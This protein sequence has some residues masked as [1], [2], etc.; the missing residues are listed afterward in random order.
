MKTKLIYLILI[1]AA[2]SFD[3]CKKDEDPKL[4]PTVTTNAVTG[5][6]VSSATLSGTITSNG[7]ATITSSGFVYSSNVAQPTTADNK[8]EITVA[9][10]NFSALLDG[11]TSGTTYHVRAYATNSVGTGYGTVVDFST[12]NLAPVA[13]AVT[14][15]GTVGTGK[16]LT[17]SYTYSDAESD[18][19]SGTT[20]KWYI[21]TDAQGAGET[22]IS[23]ATSSTYVIQAGDLGKFIR[24]GVTPKAGTGTTTGNEVKSTFAGPVLEGNLA[25][26]ASNVTVTGQAQVASQLTATYTYSDPESDVESGSTFQ[27]YVAND[28]AGAGETAISSATTQTYTIQ[29]GDLGKFI[30]FGVTPKAAT[31]KSPG[32]EVK[33]A[34]TVAVGTETVTFTYNGQ[35]VSYGV[36]VSAATGKKWLDRSLGA[37]RAAQAV[38]DYQAYGHYF[39]WGRLADTHQVVT[40]T[41]PADADVTAVNGRGTKTKSTTATP[42]DGLFVREGSAVGGTGDW[43]DPQDDNLWQGVSGVNNPCPS[44][45]R[46][47][48]KDEWTAEGITSLADGFNKLKLTYTGLR[49][50]TD[51]FFYS[52][53]VSGI[54]WTSTPTSDSGFKYSA[55]VRIQNDFQIDLLF[56]R[57]TGLNCRCI[58]D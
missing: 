32:T 17:G 7:N 5:A 52:S 56:I 8:K 36:V 35:S 37:S 13:S 49:D 48:T 39:Q 50:G 15:S 34:F 21:A 46:I 19:Q 10:G 3:A 57:E 23:G 1:V 22:A 16:T 31:G 44:G 11:L 6:T 53:Q 40:R 12:T 9:T 20:F 43:I 25:P 33:S 27:W 14:I 26:V 24:L 41:G 38:D 58:K 55:G 54:Y 4:I 51:A 29:A 18:A 30:R 47:P 45:W 28:N 2:I 42:P